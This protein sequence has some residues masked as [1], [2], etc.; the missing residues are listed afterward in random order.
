MHDNAV[1]GAQTTPLLRLVHDTMD[2][3]QVS[4]DNKLA[5]A[6]CENTMDIKVMSPEPTTG[7]SLASSDNLPAFSIDD[8]KASGLHDA[9]DAEKPSLDLLSI[10]TEKP[11]HPPE[12][13]PV[14]LLR[15]I[16][17]LVDDSPP[18]AGPSQL[19]GR[20]SPVDTQGHNS[21]ERPLNVTDALSYLDAVKV[22]FHDQPDVYNLFLDIMKEFKNE[23]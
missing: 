13:M 14:P 11:S 1:I 18:T 16:P 3:D 7:T 15:P 12:Q 21:V 9:D 5:G 10:V 23:V 22:Q 4:V 20:L 17:M 19:L 6:P 8:Q 2:G